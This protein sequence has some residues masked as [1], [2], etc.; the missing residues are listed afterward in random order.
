MIQKSSARRERFL[1]VWGLR[2]TRF[3]VLSIFVTLSCKVGFLFRVSNSQLSFSCE[4]AFWRTSFFLNKK[5]SHARCFSL[6][7]C[8]VLSRFVRFSQQQRLEVFLLPFEDHHQ[9][10]GV[11]FQTKIKTNAFPPLSLHEQ[12]LAP[13]N[14]QKGKR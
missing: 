10:A 7:F 2:C 3:I 12:R 4:N 9:F 8:K 13:M 11:C 5:D 6:F 14:A 1:T